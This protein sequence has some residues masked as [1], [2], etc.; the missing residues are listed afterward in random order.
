MYTYQLNFTW[1]ISEQLSPTWSVIL[2]SD[3]QKERKAS[4]INV[5]SI[6]DFPGTTEKQRN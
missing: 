4:G 2:L 1:S 5:Y 6:L 3:C